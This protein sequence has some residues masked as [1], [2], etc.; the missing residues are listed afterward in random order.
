MNKRLFYI[1][2]FGLML[3]TSAFVWQQQVSLNQAEN[4]YT[5]VLGNVFGVKKDLF[6][7]YDT[8]TQ[9]Q[10]IYSVKGNGN[11]SDVDTKDPLK[12]MLLYG[13]VGLVNI[14]DDRL[15]AQG[16]IDLFNLGW[17]NVSL[18]SRSFNNQIWLF[19]SIANKII[20]LNQNGELLFVSDNLVQL[21]GWESTPKAMQESDQYLFLINEHYIYRFDL[22]GAFISKRKIPQHKQIICKYPYVLIQ[23]DQQI[24]FEDLVQFTRDTLKLPSPQ[25]IN[26]PRILTNQGLYTIERNQISFTSFKRYSEGF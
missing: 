3:F 18:I 10:Y 16:E 12:I 21:V 22:Y 25:N 20:K 24:I 19:D 14:L 4:Y 7:K 23:Q 1:T 5:D 8:T 11:I 26:N 17:N 15:G 13:D 9:Q 6:W 2:C